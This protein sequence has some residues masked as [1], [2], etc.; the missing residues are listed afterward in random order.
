MA[1]GRLLDPYPFLTYIEI[2]PGLPIYCNCP[3]GFVFRVTQ[4]NQQHWRRTGLSEIY[5]GA[6]CSRLAVTLNVKR[7]IPKIGGRPRYFNFF[8]VFEPFTRRSLRDDQRVVIHFAYQKV[9]E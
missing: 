8:A 7:N 4:T 6:D 2:L 3:N 5:A 9:A 1:F